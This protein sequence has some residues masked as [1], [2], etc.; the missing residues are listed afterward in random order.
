V[1]PREHKIGFE[2]GMVLGKAEGFTIAVQD[3]II[4]Y[5]NYLKYL[6]N[7]FHNYFWQV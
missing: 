1:S 7:G 4:K 3:L 5:T 6:L 2:Q